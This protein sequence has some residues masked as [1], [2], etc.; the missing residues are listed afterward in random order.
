MRLRAAVLPALAFGLVLAAPAKAQNGEGCPA[1]TV[2]V[3]EQPAE[4]AV[5]SGFVRVKGFFLNGNEVSNVDLYVGGQEEANRVTAP[6]GTNINLPRPDVVQAF[7]AYAGTPGE[8]PGFETSFRGSNYSNGTQTVYVRITDRTGCAY[9]LAPRRVRLDNRKNQAPFGSLDFPKENA[10]VHGNGVLQV[11]GWSLDDRR[12]DHVEIYVNDLQERQA[13]LGVYRPDVYGNYP[14]VPESLLSGF[15]MNID[16]TKYPAGWYRLSVMAVDDQGQK[17]LLGSRRFQVLGVGA[18]NLPPFGEVEY[19]MLNANWFGNCFVQ[20][21]GPG[22]SGDPGFIRDPRFVM[23]VTGWALD[24]STYQDRG[25]VSHVQV[26]IDGVTIKDSRLNCGRISNLGNKL[27]DCY[28]YYRP[29]IEVLYP[30]FQQAPNCGFHFAVD[31]GWLLTQK[32]FKEGAHM[33]Q[34]K[35]YDK[36][37]Q[38]KEIASIPINMH[39]ATANLD[40]PPIGLIEDPTNYKFIN[41][42]YTVVGWT[43]DLDGVQKVRLLVDGIPQIDAV[44]KV[45]YAEY[46]LPSSDIEDVYPNYSGSANARFRFYLDTTLL[47]N[48]EHDL[49][50]EVWDS[51]GPASAGTRRFLVSNNTLVR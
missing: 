11:A 37:N 16:A 26:E 50:I 40:P 46:G 42:I 43:L 27:L 18:G 4:M 2:G 25:G 14:G 45:D 48:S 33:L 24:T 34:I 5:V 47:S 29:D 38:Y 31:V 30:G 10:S 7:P 3:I 36:E 20:L 35:A 32:G 17:G 15:I 13:V 21:G 6:G 9:F 23:Y 49:Q 12:I 22:P 41:G 1:Q 51:R 8:H 44:R 39:C 28:G 19:P